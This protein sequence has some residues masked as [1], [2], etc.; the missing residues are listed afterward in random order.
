MSDTISPRFAPAVT[1][2]GRAF[3]VDTETQFVYPFPAFIV[4][5]AATLANEDPEAFLG[6]TIGGPPSSY[7]I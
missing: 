3:V 1:I 4:Q 2:T 6:R 7:G 5:Y